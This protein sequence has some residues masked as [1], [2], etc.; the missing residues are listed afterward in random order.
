MRNLKRALSLG[1]TAAMISGLMVMGSSAASYADVTSENNVE[2]IEV[3]EAVGIMIG[4]E[5]GNFNPDQNVTRNE[6]A[7][8][9]SNLME[10]N[11]ASYKDTSPFTDVP[12]WAEPYVA[13]CWTNGITAGYSDT[14]YGGSDTVT[15]AQ[16][17]LMLMKALGYFQYASDFGS[18]WQLATTRQGNAIDLFN[19][20]DSGVT[21]AMT[22]NDVAQLVLNT[23]RSGT[24]EASTDG[25][26]TIGDV[27]INNNVRYSYIT[28]NQD[29]A[30]AIDDVKSTSNTTDA[31]R[32]VVELGE[33]LYQGDLELNDNTTDVFGRPARTWSYDS[34]EIGTYAKTELLKQSYTT[35][36]TGRDLYDLL[37]SNVVDTYDIRVAIDGVVDHDIN[38]NIFDETAINRSNKAAVGATGNGVL[39]EVYVDQENKNVNIAVINTYLAIADEDYD[40]DQDELGITVYGISEKD[41]TDEYVKNANSK[42]RTSDG[43]TEKFDLAYDDFALEDV[44]EDDVMLVTVANGEVQ[45]IADPETLSAVEISAFRQGENLTVDGTKYNYATTTEYDCETLEDYTTDGDVT[46]LKDLTYNVYLDAYGYVIG[47]VEVDAVDNYVF[48]TGVDSNY[49]NLSNTTLKANAIFLDGTMDTIE[50]NMRKSTLDIDNSVR[51]AIL[52]TWCTYS[53]NSNGVYTVTEVYNPDPLEA[54]ETAEMG[55]YGQYWDQTLTD[56]DD[57]HIWIQG[58]EDG[59]YSRVYGNDESIYLNVS[60]DNITVGNW[61]GNGDIDAVVIDDVNSVVTGIDNAN[62]EVYTEAEALDEVDGDPTDGLVSYGVYP[63]YDDEAYVIAAIVVGEDGS[64]SENLVYVHSSSVYEES[65]DKNTEEY[66]WTRTV[67]SNGEEVTL[68]EV[69]DSGISLLANGVMNEDQWY[70]VRYNADGEVIKVE[71]E[72]DHPTWLD[73]DADKVYGEWSLSNV[74]GADRYT[75]TLDTEYSA[76]DGSVTVYGAADLFPMEG[77]DTVLYHEAFNDIAGLPTVDKARTLYEYNTTTSGIR[78]ASDASIILDQVRNNDGGDVYFGTGIDDLIDFLEDLHKRSNG[79]YDYELSLL[80]EDGRATTVIIK[81]NVRDGDPGNWTEDNMVEDGDGQFRLW[82]TDNAIAKSVSY[83]ENT[84]RVDYS[85]TV[86]DPTTKLPIGGKTFTYD[87]LVYVNDHFSDDMEGL[88]GTT[89]SKGLIYEHFD[90]AAVKDNEDVDIYV[91]NVKP[92]EPKDPTEGKVTLTLTEDLGSLASIK[93]YDEIGNELTYTTNTLFQKSV[94]VDPKTDVVI[95]FGS[96]NAGRSVFAGDELIGTTDSKGRLTLT[97]T[98]NII[99]DKIVVTYAIHVGKGVSLEKILTSSGAEVT[100]VAVSGNVYYVDQADNAQKFTV[101]TTAAKAVFLST[102]ASDV[103]FT[104][105]DPNATGMTVGT[106]AT[107]DNTAAITGDVYLTAASKVDFTAANFDSIEVNGVALSADEYVAVDEVIEIDLDTSMATG[108][109][110]D[111]DGTTYVGDNDAEG[112]EYTVTE[113]DVNLKGAFQVNLEGIAAI[114]TT[115][116]DAITDGDFVTRDATIDYTTAV[117]EDG[118]DVSA[119]VLNTSSGVVYGTAVA[120]NI[121]LGSVSEDVTLSYAVAVTAIDDTSVSIY[122]PGEGLVNPWRVIQSDAGTILV[123]PGQTIGVEST[124]AS[125]TAIG[126]EETSGSALTAGED[127]VQNPSAREQLTYTTGDID[128]TV[129]DET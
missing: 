80:I 36:V 68:T 18:D 115:G 104:G 106:A 47:V 20:V 100:P 81:D 61:Y 64:N 13:A 94:A 31:N 117:D 43:Q 16:A 30:D 77:V 83:N 37:G 71:A 124:D 5:N 59:S 63:L 60:I 88:V 1:L 73:Y 38:G 21:Q 42:D 34:K 120:A 72:K 122:L 111:Y 82:G 103:V 8:V 45:T 101:K 39:T 118:T 25:S 3:L 54:T 24:V 96:S 76:V 23:L 116:G 41:N 90:I 91:R 67:I 119:N 48:L 6:M 92:V 4:D 7:V 74:E 58:A 127:F 89:S 79:N 105:S 2:A 9:M 102:N 12:S 121:A 27:T 93:I 56:V 32:F 29:Y 85:F 65:Y 69:D 51:D 52:N 35:K 26:W 57:D 98:E 114:D 87:L 28:S 19:G 66:T 46:N 40:E 97:V 70:Q 78:I 53:V 99:L 62:M 15:T 129:T 110:A 109:V 55:K 107:I 50:I 10:Y 95:D 113:K 125:I 123:L 14:I 11:V 126:L 17:A 84:D 86:I 128:V 44:V 112:G 22:R 75:N 108:I 49:S 33:Q